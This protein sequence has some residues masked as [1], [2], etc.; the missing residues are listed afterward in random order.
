[1][2]CII[3]SFVYYYFRLTLEFRFECISGDFNVVLSCFSLITEIEL[4]LIF[5]YMC[6]LNTFTWS[7]IRDFRVLFIYFKIS[8]TEAIYFAWKTHMLFPPFS[9]WSFN[10]SLF[11]SSSPKTRIVFSV[12]TRLSIWNCVKCRFLEASDLCDY[13]FLCLTKDFVPPFAK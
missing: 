4:D 2:L 5:M 11:G 8:H 12:V 13:H 3:I 1:M 9:L 10:T 7:Y 6:L